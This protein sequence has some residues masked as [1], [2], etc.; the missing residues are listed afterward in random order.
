MT[1]AASHPYPL[2]QIPGYA[3]VEQLYEGS[4]TVVYRAVET[5]SQ[6]QVIIKFLKQNYPDF[7]DLLQFRNQYTIARNLD[8]PGVVRPYKLEACGNSYA[9]VMEDFG[10]CSLRHYAQNHP[11]SLR[12]ILA[13]ALQ[14]TDILH[15]LCQHRVIHKDIKPANILIHPQS[16]QIKLIDFSI[17]SLLPKETPEIKNPTGLEGTLAYLAPEQTGRMN[18][19]I[20]YRADFYALGVTLFELLTRQLPFQSSDPMELVHCH[21]AK[22]PPTVQSLRPEIPSVLSEIVSKLMAKNAE[23]RYQSALGLQHDLQICL[24]QLKETGEIATFEIGQRDI[25]D[26]FNLPE[27]LYGRASE[28]KTLLESFERVSKGASELLLV[29]GFSGI[30]K[31]AV[32]NEVHKPIVKQRG[33]FIKGKFDQFNRNIPFSAFV[34]AFR[35][36]MGQLLSESD[37]QLAIWKTK[38]LAAVGEN[39]QVIADVIPELERIIGPQPPVAE[40]TGSAAPNRFNLLFQK[41]IQVFTT[42]EHPLVMFLDDLQ[43]ADSASLNLLKLL[44]GKASAGYL[45]ILGA[46]RDNE[47]FPA[48]PLMLT[49]EEIQESAAIVHTVTLA[50]LQ[51]MTVNQLVADTLSCSHELAYPLTHLV[52]QKTQGNPFFTT[53]FLKA[54]HEEGYIQFQPELGYW[55]CDM[56][57]VRQLALTNDVVEFMTL[58]LQKLPIETQ[59]VLKLAACIGNQFDLHTLVIVSQQPETEIAA[60]L[61]KAL[62]EGVILPIGESYRFFQFTEA[63]QTA[64]SCNITASYKFLHDRIQQAAYS[65]IPEAQKQLTH[66]SIGQL[67]LQNSDAIQQDDRLFEIVNQINCGIALVTLPTQRHQYAQLNLQA[68]RKAKESTAYRAALHYLNDGMQL[69]STDGWEVDAKLMHS[70]YEEAAEVALLNYDFEQMDSLIQVV[71]QRNNTLFEQ[72]KVYEIKLQAY[73]VKNQQLQAI[74]IGREILQKLGVI[75][76]ESATPQAIHQQVEQTLEQTLASQ[77]GR[78]IADLVT[79][80]PMQDANALAA[81]RIMISLVPSI[82]QAAPHLFPII[83]CEEVNLSLKYGNSPFSAPGYADFGIVVSSVL[84]QLEAGY[85]FGQLALQIME[86]FSEK[87]VQSMVQ[88]KVAAFN[89]SNQQSIRQAIDLLKESYR[90]GL[91]T[92][93]SVHAL[94]STS[95]RLFYTYLSGT[96]DL[97]TL[98]EEIEI[99]QSRFATSQHFLTWA[100]ILRSSIQKFTELHENPG[101]LGLDTA[102]EDQHLSFLLQENDELALHLFYLSKLILNYSFGRF[103][104]AIQDADQ[105]A[106]Y[107]KA[108]LGMPSAPIYYYYDSLIRLTLYPTVDSAQQLKLLAQVREN[109]EKLRLYANAAPMNYQHKYHLVEAVRYDVSGNRIEAVEW[110]DRAITDARTNSFIQDEALANELAGRFYLNWGKDKVA[111]SYMQEAYYCYSRWGARAKADDLENRYPRLLRSI[112]QSGAQSLNILETLAT[113]SVSH[114][115]MR[116]STNPGHSS[117]TSINTTLDFVAILKASQSLSETIQLDELLH[118]LTQIILQHSGGD[119]CAVLQPDSTGQWMVQAIATEKA[120]ELSS[121]PLEDYVNLPIKLIQ[122]AKRTQEA[123]VIDNCKTDLPVIDDYLNQHQPKSILCLPL[124]NRGHLVGMAYLENQATSHVFTRDR[125]LLLNFLCTQAAISLENARLYQAAQTYARQLEHSLEQLQSSEARFQKLADNVP[126]LIYQ[127]RIQSDGSASIPYVSSGC[128]TLYEVPA[129]DLIAGKYSLRD[130][131]HPEDQAAVFQAVV[132]SAQNLTPFRQ[133]WRIITPNGNLKWVKAASQPE[134]W[135]DGEIVWDG[136][137]I[138]ISDRKQAEMAV[139]QKSQELQAALAELQNAQL[140]MVQ[141]EKMASLGNLVAGVA[142]EINN[143]IGFLKGSINNGKDYVEDLLAH[144]ALYQQHYPQPASAI[145]NHAEEIDLEFLCEDLPKLLNSMQGASDRIQ[146]IS[147]S[148]RTFSRADTEHKVKANIHDG[149]D[150]TLLILKYRLKANEIRPEIKVI[151][152]Y[153]ELPLVECF[154]G[155]LNQVFMNILANAIDIFDEMAK[156]HSFEEIEA[157]TQSIQIHTAVVE[158]QVQIRIQDNGTGMS[159]DVQARIF[160]HLFTTKAVGKGTGLGLAI[161]RQI[162]EEKHGGTIEVNSE[163]GQGTTFIVS[164]PV[165]A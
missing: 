165:Q 9:L 59:E 67:L 5:S 131:E 29:A 73:Q 21:L 4:R 39:G 44:M 13:I 158:H 91:E 54:L 31:T 138:D 62:Q 16:Q 18:R 134:C 143:P 52:Y 120:T 108:G 64:S 70:L 55:H 103:P 98:L 96:E 145:Q 78:A 38:I 141:N 46:Y 99:Y 57:S 8:I 110:Y 135:E 90:S 42:S 104:A 37:A 58:Q 87:S 71:L 88:F 106:T 133:E 84:N 86:Q 65:L 20:D 95:F 112:F 36:L 151:K 51:E 97:A 164:L 154:P 94:V 3:L 102:D 127:I 25:S 81:L 105:G 72:L 117:S 26:R 24:T 32:V 148:L 155:Q 68:G 79:L 150:S 153:G 160:D 123:I 156:T 92:G 128:Q 12:E 11:L 7:N 136:I 80:T 41:F 109:Q 6:Q 76:P 113:G 118:Q 1:L 161:A 129:E 19:G 34:Q 89:Q 119:R 125:T 77:P 15:G 40:L 130:F 2:P 122:Y 93:D 126:G 23:D 47:V 157:H 147:T 75:L 101:C 83:A 61:W 163:P 159:K 69:L 10:G 17:A 115:S 22:C 56:V 139:L 53:Q 149:I 144:L 27:T 132:E 162:V 63:V 60:V 100:Y 35:D 30:G 142:H 107:L 121:E 14:L 28:V 114:V 43:W 74:N 66:L 85:Q 45:L 111:A 146:S 50:P 116:A 140:Q 49:L 137:L 152:N 33:Y 48:H 124:V 82:H